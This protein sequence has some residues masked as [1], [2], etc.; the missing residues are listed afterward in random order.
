MKEIACATFQTLFDVLF[1]PLKSAAIF[2]GV[3]FSTICILMTIFHAARCSTI[4][5]MQFNHSFH[6]FAPLIYDPDA[7]IRRASLAA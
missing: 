5:N 3:L 4:N 7:F 2:N 6:T 1:S